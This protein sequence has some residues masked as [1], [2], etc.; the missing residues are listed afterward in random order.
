MDYPATWPAFEAWFADEEACRSYLSGVRWP[1]GF[2]CPNCGCGEAWETS[3]GLWMCRQCGRQTSPTAGT[4]FHRSRYPL[5]VW[6]AA[7]WFVC[8]SKNGTSAL[9][10]QRMLGFGS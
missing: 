5:K 6:F 8:S 10:L 3:R 7:I 1:D 2:E 4:I 9:E